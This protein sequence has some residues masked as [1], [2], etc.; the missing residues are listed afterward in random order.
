MYAGVLLISRTPLAITDCNHSASN[1]TFVPPS[2]PSPVQSHH[3]FQLEIRLLCR[4]WLW[5][6]KYT[7]TLNVVFST[8][9]NDQCTFTQT[10]MGANLDPVF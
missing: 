7:C 8:T 5:C 6:P 1:T 3:H 9:A 2:T 10:L 4:H